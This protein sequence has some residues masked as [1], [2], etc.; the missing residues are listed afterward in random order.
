MYY[1]QLPGTNARPRVDATTRPTRFGAGLSYTT[2]TFASISARSATAGTRDTIHLKVDVSDSGARGGDLV[3][4]VYVAQPVSDVLV[5]VPPSWSPSP[6]STWTPGQ[7]TTVTLKVPP[8]RL[9]VTPGDI[10]GAGKQQVARGALRLH[11]PAPRP[12]R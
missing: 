3:V 7:S 9:A 1:Q 4:P 12:P 5:A 11:A 10:D 8:N 6:G 2:Y